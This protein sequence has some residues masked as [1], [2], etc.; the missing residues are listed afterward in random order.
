MNKKLCLFLPTAFSMM[1]F[2]TSCA[3]ENAPLDVSPLQLEFKE[4]QFKYQGDEMILEA[5]VNDNASVKSIT[6]TS[7]DST[8]VEVIKAGPLSCKVK[9]KKTFTGYVMI[10]AKSD[11]P[12]VEISAQCKVRCYNYITNLGDMSYVPYQGGSEVRALISEEVDNIILKQGL[13]YKCSMEIDT[14]FGDCEEPYNDGTQVKIESAAMT[15]LKASI[16]EALGSKNTITSFIQ[17]ESYNGI[18]TTYIKFEFTCQ[19][20]FDGTKKITTDGQQTGFTFHRYNAVTGIEN[21]DTSEILV[22]K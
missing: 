18:G 8:K 11:D 21:F 15:S 4:G 16:Q 22:I 6:F 14:A 17:N 19:E 9:K 1:F 7:S 10:T 2:I 3:K 5:T 12:F 20:V 13:T